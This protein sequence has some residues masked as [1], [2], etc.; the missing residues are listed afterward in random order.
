MNAPTHSVPSLRRV[1]RSSGGRL[2]RAVRSL[3]LARIGSRSR[4]LDG[5]ARRHRPGGRHRAVIR[6]DGRRASWQPVVGMAATPTRQG[7]W[8]VSRDGGIFS[9]GDAHYYGSTGG[10]HLADAIVGIAST[11]TGR[12]YWLVARDGGIFSFG[13]A[14]FFG[15]M[16]GRPLKQGIVGMAATPTGDG[17]WMVA[18]NGE[19]S[20]SAT[21][22]YGS[23]GAIRLNWEM[24]GMAATPSRSR[25]LDGRRRDGGIFTYGDAAFYGSPAGGP[26]WSAIMGMAPTRSGHGYWMIGRDNSGAELRR[27][28]RA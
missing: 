25:V 22:L 16:G 28:R 3:R 23:T 18:N 14:R 19:I 27:R 1:H 15:S 17:Y 8:L 7:Y 20:C 6:L 11:P 21:Q 12:G 13:D 5:A 2:R 4:L 9:F 10:I 26:R 24:V